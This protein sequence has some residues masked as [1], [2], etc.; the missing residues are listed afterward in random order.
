MIFSRPFGLIY[1]HGGF[2]PG[3]ETQTSYFPK[4]NIA[5]TLQVNADSLSGKLKGIL[6][7]FIEQLVPVL[8]KHF[9]K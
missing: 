5:L 4:W 1:G 8:E 6:N 7:R 9:G 2:F 3:Y